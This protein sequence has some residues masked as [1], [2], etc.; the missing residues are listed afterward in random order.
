MKI[1]EKGNLYVSGPGGLWVISPNG[2]HLRTIIGPEHPHNT[3]G[4]D[5]DGKTLYPCAQ[6]G[7]YRIRLNVSGIRPPLADHELAKR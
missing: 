6:K 7:L 3:A 1:D 5:D 2:K 4:G